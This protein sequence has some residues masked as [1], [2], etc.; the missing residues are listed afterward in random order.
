MPFKEHKPKKAKIFRECKKSPTG[1]H[2]FVAW[3]GTNRAGKK[4]VLGTHCD[5]CGKVGQN[6]HGHA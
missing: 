1:R 2:Q 3:T 6:Y 4:V 5:H